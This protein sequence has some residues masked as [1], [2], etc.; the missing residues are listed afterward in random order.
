MSATRA[1]CVTGMPG[2]GKEEFVKVA[3]QEGL[4]VIRMGDVVREEAR[5]RGIFLTDEGVGG[6]AK[7]E[8]R[9]HGPDIWALRTLER[10]KSE[11]VVIDGVR[12]LAEVEAFRKAFADC[13]IIVAVHASPRTRYARIASRRRRD[14]IATEEEFRVRDE[15]ELRWGLGQV[16]ALADY[17]IVNEGSLEEFHRKAREVLKRV[18]G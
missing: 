1:V 8:R 14:D 3:L 16:I 12:S 17:M 18:F 15:R 2:C 10:I 6:M 13:L 9:I 11:R 4:P 7:E 5:R